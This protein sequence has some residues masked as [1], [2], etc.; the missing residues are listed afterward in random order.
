MVKLRQFPPTWNWFGKVVSHD[1]IPNKEERKNM[2]TFRCKICIIYLSFCFQTPL[3]IKTNL[4]AF[5]LYE[6]WGP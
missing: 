1:K 2:H 4:S 6:G 5:N 3:D